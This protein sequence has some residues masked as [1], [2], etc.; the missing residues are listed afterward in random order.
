MVLKTVAAGGNGDDRVLMI[1]DE[2][3]TIIIE[4]GY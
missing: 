4:Y 1:K 3:G 2:T